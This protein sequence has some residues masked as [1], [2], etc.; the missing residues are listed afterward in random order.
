M[1]KRVINPDGLAPPRGFNHALLVDGGQVLF[2]A[3]QDASD[4]EENIVEPGDLVAQFEQAL[5]NLATVVEEA[6]GSFDDI[7]KLNVFVADA[8]DYRANLEPL[9]AAFSEHVETYP[10]MALFEVNGFF[11]PEALVEL[12]GFAV[13]DD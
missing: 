11:R 10:A 2:L 6:G 8:D 3:G 4:P 12:E 9:G 1:A 5:A 7:V 13:I